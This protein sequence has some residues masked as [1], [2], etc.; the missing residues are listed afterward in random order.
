MGQVCQIGLLPGPHRSTRKRENIELQTRRWQG[1]QTQAVYAQGAADQPQRQRGQGLVGAQFQHSGALLG[2]EAYDHFVPLV[3]RQ[4]D[5]DGLRGLVEHQP[6]L[7]VYRHSVSASDIP[8]Q[9]RA[10][11]LRD[12]TH[13]GRPG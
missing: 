13:H 11:L 7:F 3:N 10:R 1:I 12:Q 9:E 4:G 8:L 6:Q 2:A 5:D